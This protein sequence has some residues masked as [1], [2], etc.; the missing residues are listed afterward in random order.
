MDQLPR[1]VKT[2]L[3]ALLGLRLGRVWRR[4]LGDSVVQPKSRWLNKRKPMGSG[5][6]TLVKEGSV[7]SGESASGRE[8]LGYDSAGAFGIFL[9]SLS[10]SLSLSFSLSLSLSLSLALCLLK[11]HVASCH[12]IACLRTSK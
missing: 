3:V 11:S 5:G 4:V 12:R 2:F 1:E 9:L 6:L 10:L 8:Q 7:F